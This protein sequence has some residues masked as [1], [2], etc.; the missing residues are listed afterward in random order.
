MPGSISPQACLKQKAQTKHVQINKEAA[1]AIIERCRVSERVWNTSV[2]D[3][4]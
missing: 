3:V 2:E 4:E 1:M